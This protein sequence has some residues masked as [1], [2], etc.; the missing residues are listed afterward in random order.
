MDLL[1]PTLLG[2]GSRLVVLP[3]FERRLAPKPPEI[4]Q[5]VCVQT[6]G[7]H[8]RP[9]GA[10]RFTAVRAVRE[11]AARGQRHNVVERGGHGG[12]IAPRLQL[13][14]AGVSMSSAP[15]GSSTSCRDVVV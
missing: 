10:V 8:G 6:A 11:A 12:L 14:H 4:L 15:P 3:R 1:P 2:G 13:A 9:N 5:P 7:L